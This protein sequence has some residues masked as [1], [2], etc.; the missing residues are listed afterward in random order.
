LRRDALGVGVEHPHQARAVRVVAD[1][2]DKPRFRAERGGVGGHVGGAAERVPLRLH[3]HHRHG[4]LVR[5]APDGAVD[6][7]VEHHI[8]QHG[9]AGAPEACDPLGFGQS[10]LRRLGSQL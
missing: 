10:E 4:R 7:M 8:A 1:N 6:V 9:D 2:P 3:M 5:D